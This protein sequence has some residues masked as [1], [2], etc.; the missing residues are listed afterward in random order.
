VRLNGVAFPSLWKK[1]YR[2][3]VT[4]AL[5]AAE[6]VLEIEVTNLW[7]NRLIGDEQQPDDSEWG[8]TKTFTY[9]DPPV[10]IGRPLLR[11]PDWL[12]RRAPRPASGRYTFSTFKFFTKE[13]S[14]LKSGLVGPVALE[15]TPRSDPVP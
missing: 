15:M 1:P 6:N 4:S 10:A 3:E 7:P 14:L 9:V 12:R 13:T 5:H 11:E 2:L 8:E